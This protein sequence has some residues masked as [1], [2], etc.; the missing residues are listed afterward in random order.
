MMSRKMIWP[1]AGIVSAIFLMIA[2]LC[3]AAENTE[4]GRFDR[5]TWDLALRLINFALLA[6]VVYKYGKP[7][8]LKFLASKRKEQVYRFE[9]LEK[10]TNDLNKQLEEQNTE[11]A[12][13]D[14]RIQKIKNYYH[15]VGQ[16]EKERIV[17]EAELLKKQIQDNARQKAM[18]EF[19]NAKVRFRKEVV[20]KAV[21]LAEQRI[22]DNVN[23]Q[24]QENFIQGYLDQLKG[25]SQNAR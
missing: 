18:A 10:R 13:I 8:L 1:V 24:D 25:L 17:A 3:V 20:D 12:K 2:L 23:L 6:F 11:L 9:D 7:P 4:E 22:R 19:E 16:E 21:E 15:Q 14:E 5:H